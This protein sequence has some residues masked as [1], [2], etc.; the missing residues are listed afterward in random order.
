VEEDGSQTQLYSLKEEKL[1]FMCFQSQTWPLIP[2]K[3]VSGY[4]SLQLNYAHT[5]I[6]LCYVPRT[7]LSALQKIF[8]IHKNP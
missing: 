1:G 3:K 6:V 5:H 7:V 4:E 8:K 2:K